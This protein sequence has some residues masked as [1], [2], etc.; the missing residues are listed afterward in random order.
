M[1][2]GKKV[3]QRYFRG[4]N[5]MEIDVDVGSSV[6]ASQIVGISRGY[7]KHFVC[8]IGKC[9][10]LFLSVSDVYLFVSSFFQGLCC[11]ERKRRSYLRRC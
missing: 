6:I 10:L 3:V 8:N 4:D 2:L 7:C 11:R 1:L 5:Y 9:S